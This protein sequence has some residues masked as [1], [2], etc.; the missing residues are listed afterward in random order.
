MPPCAE[1]LGDWAVRVRDAFRARV[2][3]SPV[4]RRFRLAPV[5]SA[6]CI[7]SLAAAACGGGSSS[8]GSAQPTGTTTVPN[9]TPVTPI[10][11]DD[12]APGR[13]AHP[14]RERPV[15]DHAG[16]EQHP[17]H[18]H[19]PAAEARRLD[20]RHQDEP[21]PRRRQHPAGR[22]HPLAPR[23]VAEPRR[24][25]T[26]RRR[27]CPN[28]SSPPAKRRRAWCCPTGYGYQY[29]TT[30]HWLLNY[31]LH[32]QLSKPDQVWVTYDIDL[33]PAT[34]A[35]AKNIKPAIPVWMDVQ[36]GSIVS[37]V[38][39][40]PG[41]RHERHVHVPRRRE[42]PVRQRPAEER[43]DGA[44]TTARCSRPPATCTPAACTTTCGCTRRARPRS[45]ATPRRA[46]PTP[47]TCSR[48][49]RRTSSPRARSRGT[50][51]CRRRRPTGGSRCKKGDVL[52]TTT[53]YDSKTA[54]W[55]ESMGIM[56]VWMAPTTRP[57]PTRSRRRSTSPG[58]LT[59]GHLAEND[60]HGGKPD[61][62]GLRG[63]DEAAVEARCR[64][65]RCCRSPTSRTQGDMSVGA[66]RC[67]RSSRAASLVFRN[68]DA[69][70]RHPAH[71]H[72]VQGCRAT[73]RPASR[74]PLANGQPQFDS[75]E[76]GKRRPPAS[77]KVDLD[78]ADRPARRAPT[79]TSAASTRSCAARSASSAEVRNR[80]A[81]PGSLDRHR[82]RR[83]VVVVLAASASA[84]GT[85]SAT[86][87]R[88]KPTLSRRGD[89]RRPGGPATPDGN[90]EGRA[91]QRTC[92]SA[93]A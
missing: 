86:T 65:A 23:R 14:P 93:T 33:I 17:V 25:R 88:P 83:V 31:M 18:A 27:A 79:P 28:A 21:A 15:P 52:S 81:S 46:R 35:A 73:G 61:A 36:N 34:S 24:A 16:P 42:E 60:N 30:D 8:K 84:R 76:L 49:S 72:R 22:R 63:H 62:E 68:D 4:M 38:R 54:S 41:Q 71:D 6:V 44:A 57:A 48:R 29:K 43:V 58:V 53:T 75:G 47:R 91:G 39:R 5:V 87:R 40:A 26:R 56:V 69:T 20:R 11:P 9:V 50:S 74:I 10:L 7:F 1:R 66:R 64:R 67:R 59:H 3:Y 80:R 13:D 37:G 89:R 2:R 12:V 70:Q 55:Y 78:D 32:N 19:D 85:C 77:G 51:R 82:R 90:V 45:R 92:T